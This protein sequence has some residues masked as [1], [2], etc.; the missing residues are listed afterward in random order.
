MYEWFKEIFEKDG[1]RSNQNKGYTREIG[2]DI[3]EDRTAG[4][5]KE[6]GS[7]KTVKQ[8]KRRSDTILKNRDTNWTFRKLTKR[9][10]ED[11]KLEINSQQTRCENW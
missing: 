10:K 11:G 1:R 9:K 8:I 3:V 5:W 2:M 6:R 7:A 4:K